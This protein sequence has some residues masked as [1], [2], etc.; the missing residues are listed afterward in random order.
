LFFT[1]LYDIET[2]ASCDGNLVITPVKSILTE[3]IVN[4]LKIYFDKL[5]PQQWIKENID[6]FSKLKKIT[7]T[8]KG[9]TYIYYRDN[10]KNTNYKSIAS[11][12]QKNKENIFNVQ[13]QMLNYIMTGKTKAHPDNIN[14]T[15]K[16][17]D[18]IIENNFIIKANIKEG[19]D[20]LTNDETSL[21]NGN[22]ENFI[23]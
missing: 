12:I 5:L 13:F 1:K 10:T 23:G 19:F 3:N 8:R 22:I 15:K 2:R 14:K 17:S 18:L 7:R 11:Y 21:L 4:F 6:N 20:E 9:K 16:I